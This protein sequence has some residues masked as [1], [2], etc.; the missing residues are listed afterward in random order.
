VICVTGT[1][2]KSTTS[3]LLGHVL[4]VLGYKTV[5]LG[6]IGV[7]VSEAPTGMDFYVLEMSSYQAADFVGP[8][9]IT[10]VTSPSLVKE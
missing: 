3:S 1:K 8:C 4:N 5:V 7:P 9:D 6:N 2:G 10:A